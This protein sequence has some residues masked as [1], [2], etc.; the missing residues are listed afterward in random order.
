VVSSVVL[1]FQL[2]IGSSSG[3]CKRWLSLALA[4]AQPTS[5]RL[6]VK[7]S[8]GVAMTVDKARMPRETLQLQQQCNSSRMSSRYHKKQQG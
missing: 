4:Y 5:P 7:V 3:A 8:S 1:H 6:I 2:S